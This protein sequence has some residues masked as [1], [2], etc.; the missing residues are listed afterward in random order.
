M[1]IQVS[2]TSTTTMTGLT[3]AGGGEMVRILGMNTGLDVDSI[4][5]KMMKGEQTKIDS[6]KQAE[7]LVEWKQ[8]GYQS[9][10][11]DIK[12]F[13][14]KYFDSMNKDTYVLSPDFS[15]HM[16]HHQVMTVWLLYKQG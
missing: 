5:T 7:Q 9:I 10:I 16:L 14:G 1:V 8:E 15:H 2:D 11:A 3:G 12:T 13:Q 4:V 6:A